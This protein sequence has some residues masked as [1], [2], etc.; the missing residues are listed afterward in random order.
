MYVPNK[1][2]LNKFRVVQIPSAKEIINRFGYCSG[3]NFSGE[4]TAP[5]SMTKTQLAA[6][7]D[8]ANEHMTRQEMVNSDYEENK[9]K[10]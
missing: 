1:L 5:L 6:V 3:T 8:N 9:D 2:K 4:K 10:L 7:V